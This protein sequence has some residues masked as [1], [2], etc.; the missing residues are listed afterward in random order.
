M[1]VLAFAFAAFADQIELKNGDRLSG[2][3]I[4]QDAEILVLQTEFAGTIT[5]SKSNIAK[6][7]KDE[8]II[9]EIVP[10]QKTLEEKAA[11]R[12]GGKDDTEEIA[13]EKAAE[14]AKADPAEPETEKASKKR[15][16]GITTG[17][18]GNANVGFS[19]TSGN[20]SNT[21]FT[22]G[23]R[24]EKPGES[25]KWTTYANTLWNRNKI[26]ALNQT[27]SNAIWGGLRYD[28]NI[29]KK[30]FAFGSFDFERDRPQRLNMRT[31]LGGGLGYHAIQNDRTSL[32]LFSGLAYNRT[33][34]V[35][36]NKNAAELLIGDSFKH[37]F[38]DKVR[39]QQGFVVYPNLSDT[40]KFRF[41]F[42]S[43]LSADVTKRI[44]WFVSIGDR[45]NSAPPFITI[46]KSDF[47]F[48]TGLK[49][50]FGKAK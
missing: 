42:D 28:R 37:A 32:D 45:Y 35:G 39:F 2:K 16:L 8:D 1:F 18:D 15:G 9:K 24:A 14:A 25:S 40:G 3:I 4:K 20:S 50:A 49:M 10:A 27:T 47:L 29:T 6:H 11:D 23:M 13:T 48:A 33:W 22:A 30:V 41:V 43:T 38:N 12:K 7:I 44:G 17:W 19:L 26:G 21:L 34:Y 36:P 31:V 46:K 5:I